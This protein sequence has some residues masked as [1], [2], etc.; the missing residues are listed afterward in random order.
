MYRFS[1]YPYESIPEKDQQYPM[2]TANDPCE[3]YP[4]PGKPFDGSNLRKS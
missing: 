2:T 3:N 4:S 1:P